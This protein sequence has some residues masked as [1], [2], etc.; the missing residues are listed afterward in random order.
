MSLPLVRLARGDTAAVTASPLL[1]GR[2]VMV[3]GAHGGLGSAVARAAAAAGATVVLVG[4]KVRAL[5]K[6]YDELEAAGVP[7]PAI[8][9]VNLQGATPDEY[10][11][12]VATVADQLGRL[13][14]LVHAAARFEG[15]TPILHHAPDVWLRVLQ[16]NLSAPFALT[17]A[18]LPLLTAAPDSAVVF[19]TDDPDEVSGAH[20]GAYGVAK[21]GL[22]RLASILH[23]EHDTDNLRVHALLP[24]P[25]RTAIRRT[26]WPGINPMEWPLP[27]ATARVVVR[28]LSAEGHA[29]RGKTL[30]L[31]PS[32][33]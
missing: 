10:A 14:A 3:T 8:A 33:E 21:A 25:M 9:P 7:R 4:H 31:R 32:P 1:Q 23:E 2:V 15:L 19:V 16:V 27:D 24:G 11:Q 29:W 5:E 26:A 20:W 22:E 6:L 17:Q 28:M 30:D 18:C 13:D 12:V